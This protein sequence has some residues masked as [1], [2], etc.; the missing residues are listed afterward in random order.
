MDDRD[1]ERFALLWTDDAVM[2]IC[3]AGPGAPPTATLRPKHFHLAFE[4][5]GR[6][7]RTLHHVTTHHADVDAANGE[8]EGITCCA[9]HHLDPP[10][11]AAAAD[12]VMHIR[13]LDRYRR[14]RDRWRFARRRI[15]ILFRE[16]VSVELL[17]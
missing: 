12:L 9:A 11:G 3:E 7:G 14:D 17:P 6:Y 4:A 10:D 15:E 2:E 16:R 8:A 1:E 13:Y 5:L